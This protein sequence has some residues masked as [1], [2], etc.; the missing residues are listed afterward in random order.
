MY[1]KKGFRDKTDKRRVSASGSRNENLTARGKNAGPSNQKSTSDQR[2]GSSSKATHK[3]GASAQ[4][5]NQK[6]P[7]QNSSSSQHPVSTP[8]TT[9]AG[10]SSRKDTPKSTKPTT[11]SQKPNTARNTNFAPQRQHS[12]KTPNSCC[13]L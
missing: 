9:E 11:Q 6:S 7:N 8:K 1:P 13:T 12:A 2:P 5:S 3:T 4:K 10:A